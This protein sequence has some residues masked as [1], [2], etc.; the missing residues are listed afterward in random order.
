LPA[1]PEAGIIQKN[2][3]REGNRM[4]RLSRRRHLQHLSAAFGS[5]AFSGWATP[6]S[7]SEPDIPPE[8]IGKGITHI[9]YSD[10]GG[11]PDSV[12]VMF[13]RDHV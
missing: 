3:P 4:L 11:R 7:A 8:G 12:Q 9:S 13:N 6:S 1:P 2:N 5:A 10:I